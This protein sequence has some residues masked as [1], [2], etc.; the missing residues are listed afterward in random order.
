VVNV[1]TST[2]SGSQLQ[3]RIRNL[4]RIGWDGASPLRF[5]QATQSGQPG[6]PSQGFPDQTEIFTGIP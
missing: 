5:R 1:I 2:M 4:D 3:F 6:T